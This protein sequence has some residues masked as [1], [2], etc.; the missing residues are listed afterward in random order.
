M[1]TLMKWSALL[2]GCLA[3]VSALPI[4]GHAAP[5]QSLDLLKSLPFALAGVKLEVPKACEVSSQTRD[6]ETGLAVRFIRMFDPQQS[7]MI[8]R[9]DVLYGFGQLRPRN[10]AVRILTA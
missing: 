10:C 4:T 6:P 7:K 3:L 2:V 8:N 1:R 9:F 5:L